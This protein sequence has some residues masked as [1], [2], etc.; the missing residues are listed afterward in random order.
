MKEVEREGK[1]IAESCRLSR[2]FLFSEIIQLL[3]QL[4]Q[5]FVKRQLAISRHQLVGREAVRAGETIPRRGNWPSDRRK[6]VKSG[7]IESCTGDLC[8]GGLFSRVRS[9]KPL[10]G[11]GPQLVAWG[12]YDAFGCGGRI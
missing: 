2:F 5:N 10:N 12:P 3:Q 8:N 9:T 6:A 4:R 11:N 7:S 1:G